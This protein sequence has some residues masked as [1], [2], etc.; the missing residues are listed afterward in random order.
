LKKRQRLLWV[1]DPWNTLD[2]PRDTTLRLAQAA[3]ALG[4]S[5]FWCDVKSIRLENQKICLDGRPIL[6]IGSERSQSSFEWGETQIKSPKDFTWI[7]YRTDPPVDHAYLH[8]LQLIALDLQKSKTTEVVNP[9]DVLFRLNEKLE[10]GALEEVMPPTLVSSQWEHLKHFGETQGRTVLK[11]LHEAQSHGIEL[12]DWEDHES[13]E[14]AQKKLMQATQGFQMPVLLQKYLPGISEG[15]TRLWFVD[16]KL[17]AYVKKLP[18]KGDFRVDMD[19]GSQLA[20]TSLTAKEKKVA[21][22][23]AKHLKYRKI[24]LAAVDLIENLITDFNFTSPGLIPQMESILNE[25][26]SRRIMNAVAG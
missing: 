3:T 18:M 22:Q 9:L 2:H 21:T 25:N 8:P 16:G 6:S 12:L 13:L 1:T 19:R 11:P 10:A 5:Q 14:V 20:P 26:L 4:I 15:E 24:R 23:I 17:L 7:H